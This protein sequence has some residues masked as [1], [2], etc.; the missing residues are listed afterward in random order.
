MKASREPRGEWMVST[1]MPYLAY[2][3]RYEVRRS[4]VHSVQCSLSGTS[5]CWTPN[6]ASTLISVSLRGPNCVP[7]YMS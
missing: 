7:T 6:C 1:L 5:T 3:S 4:T 2:F